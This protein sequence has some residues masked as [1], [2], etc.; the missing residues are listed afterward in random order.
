MTRTIPTPPT[1]IA[2]YDPTRN[3]AGCSWDGEA[4]ARAVDFFPAVLTHPDDSPSTKTADPFHLQPW[5]ADYVATLFGWRRPDGSR[6]YTES[7]G[8]VPRKNGKTALAAGLALYG[9]A[10]EGKQGAQIYSAAMDRDQASAIYRTASRMVMQN[11]HLSRRLNCIDSTKRITYRQSGSFYSALSGDANTGHSKK[12]YFVL[13]D[14]LHTQKNRGLYDNLQTGMGSTTNRLFVSITTAG[15]DRESICFKVWQHA[16]AVRD[17]HGAEFPYFLPLLYELGEKDDWNDERTWEKCN[18]NLGVSISRDFLREE[19]AKAKQ[20]P[21]NEN[22]F[23]N[24][25]LNQWVEQAIRWLPMDAW[26]ECGGELPD[27][28]G[29]PCWGGLDMSSTTDVTA[30]C[31]V[32]RLPDDAFAVLPHFF[33]P[34]DT[35]RLK[36]TSDRVPYRQWAQQGFVTLT[37][38][39]QVDHSFVRRYILEQHERFNIQEIAA[40]RWNA[41]QIITDLAGDGLNVTA[42][43]QGFASMSGPAKE[44]EKLILARKFR[45][46]A[47]PVLRWMAGNVAVI[48]DA[49]ENIKPVKDKSTGRI[50]GIV[51]SI[52]ALGRAIAGVGTQWFNESNALEIG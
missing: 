29:E 7:L 31:L 52:M 43:G 34:E 25:Y 2:G 4:A 17:N 37:P 15:W 1:N 16:R 33:I 13:F 8:A 10:A 30:F 40:D 35:A 3:T 50:D 12:P 36:E 46:G 38:G 27:L 11:P 20:S 9:L 18:P 39:N 26:D 22:V 21:S 19:Y 32:F 28:S 49:A 23:R 47:N 48:R 42:F 6:R 45:H 24:L 41:S 44:L 51:A 5:Q 14:E